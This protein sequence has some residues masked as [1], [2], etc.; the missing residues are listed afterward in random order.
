MNQDPFQMDSLGASKEHVLVVDDDFGTLECLEETA[1]VMGLAVSAASTGEDALRI[2]ERDQ[3]DLVVT[4]V[5]MPGMDGLTLTQRIKTL[6]P[7][8]PVIIVTGHGDEE[9]AVAALKAGA[10]DYLRKPFQLLE[11]KSTIVRSVSLVRSRRVEMSAALSVERVESY[12]E[13][14]NEPEL[15]S[16]LLTCLLRPVDPWLS[17]TQRLHLR[18]ACQELLMNAI[19]H[20]NLEISAEEKLQ[21]VLADSYER[22]LEARRADPRLNRRRVRVWIK[23]DVKERRFVCRICDEGH[24]FD[25]RRFVSASPSQM[26]ERMGSGRG[27]F[28][29]QTLLSECRY[30]GNGN[31][32]TV[33][34]H[35]D[36][37][38]Q[39]AGLHAPSSGVSV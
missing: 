20:G 14:K 4:D 15:V 9:T 5:R 29:I 36:D 11:L 38:S 32:V 10:S 16:G 2:F 3:P 31:E 6:Q 35:Y 23:H 25:W 12:Y 8:C 28:L 27:I 7:D 18:V 33:T 13:L 39:A 21:A 34:I 1:R 22:L 26:L 17:E 19:E 24:G 30:H 37:Q